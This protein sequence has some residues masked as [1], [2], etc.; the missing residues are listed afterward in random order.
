MNFRAGTLVIAG[1]AAAA[2]ASQLTISLP[3]ESKSVKFAVIGDN[4]TGK[5]PEIAVAKLMAQAHES[6]PFEFVL[7]LG[8]NM[9]GGES[10]H[11]FKRKFEDPY[12]PLLAAGV[13]FY[14]S[15][16]NHDNPNQ[17]YYKPFN[18]NGKRFYDFKKGNAEF[19]AL[20]SNYMDPEQLDWVQKQLE[21]SRADW[22]ICFF[23]HPLYSDGRAHGPDKDLRA[24]LEPIFERTGV[25]V[26]FSGHE[27]FYERFK[28][29]NGIYYFIEG[30]SGQLRFH[31]LRPSS[32]TAKGFDTDRA[33]MLIEIAGDKLYFQ[34]I[35]A[36]GDTVDSGEIDRRREDQKSVA[37]E[38]VPPALR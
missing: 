18:M 5:E 8:D 11:D 29:Q 4:G 21:G 6:F 23:H 3:R 24:R 34:T 27:H 16:G 35:A 37:R 28:P 10:E 31:N 30:S 22:K 9:Y 26:V 17:R 36:S 14:A 25:N 19:L 2:A 7:M 1:L 33:F 32:L 38:A 13:K 12:A 15:L 20:D